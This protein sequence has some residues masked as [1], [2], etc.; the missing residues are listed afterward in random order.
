MAAD[1]VLFVGTTR[2]RVTGAPVEQRGIALSLDE[3][4]VWY[5]SRAI[6]DPPDNL[7]PQRER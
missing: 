5:Q 7:L 3:D 2:G 4:R 6:G 1:S